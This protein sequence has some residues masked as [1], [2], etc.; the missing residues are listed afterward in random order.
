M[1][2]VTGV[3]RLGVN[4]QR[5]LIQKQ[6]LRVKRLSISSQIRRPNGDVG[7][8]KA[9]PDFSRSFQAITIFKLPL[10]EKGTENLV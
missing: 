9:E 1:K 2:T 8:A 7:F 10:N 5:C 6:A 4:L 3:F